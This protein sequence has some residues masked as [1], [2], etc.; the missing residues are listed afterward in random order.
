MLSWNWITLSQLILP[1]LFLESNKLR[2]SSILSVFIFCSTDL[3]RIKGAFPSAGLCSVSHSEEAMLYHLKLVFFSAT[4]ASSTLV[5]GLGTSCST[6]LA[7]GTAAPGD[8][9]WLE[10]IHHQGT[11]A[12]NPNPSSY[13]V[14]R[15]VKD[16]G[17]KGDGVT[18]D[19]AA[20]KRVA[21]LVSKHSLTSATAR[22]CL[23]VDVAVADLVNLPRKCRTPLICIIH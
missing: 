20:I 8:P 22:P 21:F 18:D 12:F 3:S 13:K 19:T 15:N 16:F 7:S 14:F 10:S 5:S 17:A 1:Y 2:S 9:Y 6:P 23:L 11:S 4:I